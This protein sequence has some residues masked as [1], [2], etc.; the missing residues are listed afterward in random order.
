[1][2]E[3]IY[4]VFKSYFYEIFIL[5]LVFYVRDILCFTLEDAHG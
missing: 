4:V 3:I 2:G 5:P 1:M